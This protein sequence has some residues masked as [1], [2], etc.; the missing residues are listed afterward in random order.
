[1]TITKDTV[2]AH[3]KEWKLTK[4]NKYTRARR[5]GTTIRCPNCGHASRV[6]HFSWCGLQC[7]LCKEM[8]DKQNWWV[9]K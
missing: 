8:V 3:A 2:T 1:M 5:R 4:V 9:K 7:S 6:Y